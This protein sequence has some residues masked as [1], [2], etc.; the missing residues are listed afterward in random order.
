M[1]DFSIEVQR[2]PTPRKNDMQNL[3]AQPFVVPAS[4]GQTWGVQLAIERP[5][6]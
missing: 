6:G 3:K 4:A 2:A 5:A 1:I